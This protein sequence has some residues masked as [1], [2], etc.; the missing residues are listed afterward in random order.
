MADHLAFDGIVVA[1]A[2]VAGESGPLE[3]EDP[4]LEESF[5]AVPTAA[6]GQV[7]AALGAARLAFDRG[8]VSFTGSTGIGRRIA[9]QAAPTVKRVL[10]ELG[11]K[12]VGLYLPDALAGLTAGVA[13][14][15]GSLAGQGC[16][17]QTRI[18]VPRES[19]AD[20]VEQVGPGEPG[21]RERLH[22]DGR[23]QA[24]RDRPRA[25]RRGIPRVPGTQARSRQRC[26]LTTCPRNPRSLCPTSAHQ[27]PGEPR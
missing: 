1:G 5:T 25:R 21:L 19:L 27:T 9:A 13:T 3:V 4:A 2:S 18:L 22:A 15:L 26:P 14:V 20:A 11:G 8:P 6:L 23:G 16:A 12:S 24:E 17:L 10:L 7:D